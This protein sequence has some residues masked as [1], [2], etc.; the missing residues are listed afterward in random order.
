[1]S[2]SEERGKG[3]TWCDEAWYLYAV[4]EICVIGVQ[5]KRVNS[6]GSQARLGELRKST[7]LTWERES[8][9]TTH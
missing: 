8:S 2:V 7:G 9:C 5:G 4:L 3:A 1:M 6:H